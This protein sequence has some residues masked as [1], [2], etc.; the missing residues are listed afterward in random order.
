M[1]TLIIGGGSFKNK[2]WVDELKTQLEPEIAT[3]PFYFQVWETGEGVNG[4]DF[5]LELDK[6][7]KMVGDQKFNLLCKS[8][9]SMLGM[10]ILEKIP[11]QV[12]KII[13][14]GFPLYDFPAEDFEKYIVLNKF[15]TG[16][17]LCFQNNADPHGSFAEA[18]SFIEKVNPDIKIVEKVAET[19]DYPYFQDFKDFLTK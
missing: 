8:V 6:A 10:L 3:W 7:L 2:A 5:P 16:N 4:L 17:I 19:H 15:P 11:D 13:V 18:K 12:E 14:C 1:Q 9:G